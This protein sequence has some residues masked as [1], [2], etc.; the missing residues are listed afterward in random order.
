V[1]NTLTIVKIEANGIYTQGVGQ[2]IDFTICIINASSLPVA[3]QGIT[4][5]MPSTWQWGNVACDTTSTPNNPFIACVGPSGPLGGT[6]AWGHQDNVSPLIMNP[7]ARI[8]LRIHGT[9]IASNPPCNGPE[10][11]GIGYKVTLADTT[12]LAGNSACITVP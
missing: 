2:P 5:T 10:S 7:G 9:Y 4:D 8:D 12:V 1:P 6:Y 3:I 11:A